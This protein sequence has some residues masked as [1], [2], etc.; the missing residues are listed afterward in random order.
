MNKQQS[1]PLV[2]KFTGGGSVMQ[3]ADTAAAIFSVGACSAFVASGGDSVWEK[4]FRW[5]I[6]RAV[7]VRRPLP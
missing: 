2:D 1:I 6:R 5:S 4:S 7:S 3:A